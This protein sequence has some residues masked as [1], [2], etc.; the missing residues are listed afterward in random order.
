[1]GRTALAMLAR[2][3]QQRITAKIENPIGRFSILFTYGRTLRSPGAGF[4]EDPQSN[5]FAKGDL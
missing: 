3:S 4:I 5:L 1:M 2:V